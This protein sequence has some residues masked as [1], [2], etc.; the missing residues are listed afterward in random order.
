LHGSGP[1]A[2]RTEVLE[3]HGRGL[4][5]AAIADLLNISDRRVKDFLANAV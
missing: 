3:L 5:P 2:L 4:V 1:L